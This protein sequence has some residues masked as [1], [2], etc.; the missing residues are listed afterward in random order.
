MFM[1]LIECSIPGQ[2]HGTV[3]EPGIMMHDDGAQATQITPSKLRS[4][5]HSP[6]PMAMAMAM[7]AISA[8]QEGAA[9]SNY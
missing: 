6:M 1:V 7:T 3:N 8:V 4:G 2:Y 5:C 9:P